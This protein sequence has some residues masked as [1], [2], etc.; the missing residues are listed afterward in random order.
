MALQT[1]RCCNQQHGIRGTLCLKALQILV[2]RCPGVGSQRVRRANWQKQ[3]DN[4]WATWK[5]KQKSTAC[6]TCHEKVTP[7]KLTSSISLEICTFPCRLCWRQPG[8][9]LC[10]PCEPLLFPRNSSCHANHALVDRWRKSVSGDA[11]SMKIIANR[12]SCSD[13]IH[14]NIQSCICGPY[15]TISNLSDFLKHQRSPFPQPNV[16]RSKTS[17]SD[18]ISFQ[19]HL[20]SNTLQYPIK[21]QK[22][23]FTKTAPGSNH[24]KWF[25]HRLDGCR[26]RRHHHHHH[27]HQDQ[28]HKSQIYPKGSWLQV[29]STCNSITSPTSCGN[30]YRSSSVSPPLLQPVK[31]HPA[32]RSKLVENHALYGVVFSSFKMAAFCLEQILRKKKAWIQTV[33]PLRIETSWT[34]HHTFPILTV[35][36][37]TFRWCPQ[38]KDMVQYTSEN[39][40][41]WT[42][43]EQASTPTWPPHLP[44]SN[45]SCWPNA[46]DIQM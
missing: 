5:I 17:S 16:Q 15:R 44:L 10:H 18:S 41:A 9:T 2:S 3:S 30:C 25:H 22:A 12:A 32:W 1:P 31:S 19:S 11:G 6:I 43:L 8:H 37:L 38:P 35:T 7:A 28:N 46:G 36:I 40:P 14:K 39:P 42:V 20:A 21:S 4:P 26:R 13:S 33:K 29:L 45:K 23:T 34:L 27:H 24:P